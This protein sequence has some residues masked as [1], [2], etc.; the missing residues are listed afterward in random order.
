NATPAATSHTITEA[1]IAGP[2]VEEIP[3]ELPK[4]AELPALGYRSAIEKLGERFHVA[5]ALLQK[6]NPGARFAAGEAI[7][8]PNV[9]PFD[10]DPKPAP[11]A[12]AA[13]ATVQVTRDDSSLR[14]T[15]ADGTIVFFAPVT[16][17]S[18]HDPLPPGDWKVVGVGWHPPFHY[19]PDLFWDAK[20]GDT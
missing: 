17:G 7:Q 16:T 11:D 5:P 18:E 2:F 6:M 14:V 20:P 10:P 4:Q 15:R 8:V 19:N 1:D 12:A 3:E 13:D 9:Q